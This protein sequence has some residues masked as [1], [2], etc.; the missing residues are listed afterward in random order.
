MWSKQIT[1]SRLLDPWTKVS[2]GYFHLFHVITSQRTTGH[3]L[4]IELEEA[5][6]IDKPPSLL[7]PEETKCREVIRPYIESN[8]CKNPQFLNCALENTLISENLWSYFCL[9]RRNLK[10]SY[11]N[12]KNSYGLSPLSD[13][14]ASGATGWLLHWTHWHQVSVQGKVVGGLVLGFFEMGNHRQPYLRWNIFNNEGTFHVL[15]GATGNV[16]GAFQGHL[17]PTY[18]FGLH[19]HYMALHK[20]GTPAWP[21]MPPY[22]LPSLA[23]S[24]IHSMALDCIIPKIILRNRA[25]SWRLHRKPTV[26]LC[27]GLVGETTKW[28]IIKQHSEESSMWGISRNGKI[29]EGPPNQ[30]SYEKRYHHKT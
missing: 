22:G 4:I 18:P 21:R 28:I 27:P 13:I 23:V 29:Q 10:N 1:Q 14:P 2:Y 25:M 30:S 8:C 9:F 15:E 7:D 20:A 6:G 24:S 11:G 19:W 26:A 3:R 17:K 12:S 16:R 5:L